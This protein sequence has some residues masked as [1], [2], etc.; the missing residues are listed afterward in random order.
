MDPILYT[1]LFARPHPEPHNTTSNCINIYTQIEADLNRE[2][3]IV[4]VSRLNTGYQIS[5]V[6]DLVTRLVMIMIRSN[7]NPGKE[8]VWVYDTWL[9]PRG[10]IGGHDKRGIRIRR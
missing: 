1:P 6:K 10:S 9:R 8:W 7:K 2:N 4:L 3:D 5:S